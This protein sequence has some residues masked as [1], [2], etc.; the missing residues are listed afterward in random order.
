MP[1]RLRVVRA[2]VQ[3]VMLCALH[4]FVV[5]C[6]RDMVTQVPVFSRCSEVFIN[7][8]VNRLTISVFAPSAIIIRQV[9]RNHKLRIVVLT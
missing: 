2:V 8:L 3:R 5:D 9:L 7:D 6:C 4:A 1:A